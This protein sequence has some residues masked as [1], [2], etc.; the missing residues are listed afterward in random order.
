[1]SEGGIGGHGLPEE[2]EGL[3]EAFGRGNRRRAETGPQSKPESHRKAPDPQALRG[4][5]IV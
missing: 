5:R 3:P 2:V 1:M 4:K